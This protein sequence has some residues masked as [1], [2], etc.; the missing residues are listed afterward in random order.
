VHLGVSAVLDEGEIFHRRYILGERRSEEVTVGD[1][2]HKVP[3]RVN[4]WH[5]GILFSAKTFKTAR[6]GVSG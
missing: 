2:T 1:E 6:A 3:V 4:H 5:P